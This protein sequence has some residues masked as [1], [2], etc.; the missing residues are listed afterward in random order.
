MGTRPWPTPSLKHLKELTPA[1]IHINEIMPY[2]VVR[3]LQDEG[4]GI[5]TT[6]AAKAYA[7]T[8]QAWAK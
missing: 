7:D 3:E 4:P 2:V 6:V 5:D 1:I 8:Q